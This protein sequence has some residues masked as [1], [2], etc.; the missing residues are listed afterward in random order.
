LGT[1]KSQ[2]QLVGITCLLVAAK[3]EEIMCPTIGDCVYVTDYTYNKKQVAD[4]E[5]KILSALNFN[6]GRPLPLHFLRRFTMAAD[7]IKKFIL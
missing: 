5:M 6:I 1:P 4:M 7:V 2:L 3:Y